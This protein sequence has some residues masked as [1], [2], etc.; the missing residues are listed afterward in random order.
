MFI[1]KT[2]IYIS[3]LC[4]IVYLITVIHELVKF[5]FQMS[6]YFVVYDNIAEIVIL[7]TY[8]MNCE[9]FMLK[10]IDN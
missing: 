4:V 5:T 10:S 8:F 6:L 7:Q 2:D 9:N 3:K 1:S